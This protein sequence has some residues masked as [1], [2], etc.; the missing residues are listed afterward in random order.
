M[1]ATVHLGGTYFCIEGPQ[2]STRAESNIYRKWDVDVIGMTNVTEAKL[3]REAEICYAT[4]ALATDYDCWHAHE[5][6]VTV[7]TVVETL[8]RNVQTAKDII[9]NAVISLPSARSCI[10]ADALKNAIITDTN[11]IPENVKQRLN[12]LIGKYI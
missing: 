3:A 4:L 9:K 2:F 1:G 7:E 8:K 6:D 12:L 5:E 10:C 11:S